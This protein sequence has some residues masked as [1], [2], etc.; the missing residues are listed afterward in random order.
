[1]DRSTAR[2]RRAR[3]ISMAVLGVGVAACL[4][5]GAVLAVPLA[6]ASEPSQTGWW[7]RA[8]PDAS[9]PIGG[10]PALPSP[11]VPEDGLPVALVLGEPSRVSGLGVPVDAAPGAT[12]TVATL[13]I[14]ELDGG[15]T[16]G[17]ADAEIVACP[18]LEFW[19]GEPAQAYESLPELDC[20]LAVTGERSE[21]GTWTFDLAIIATAWLDAAGGLSPDG[22]A[23][24]PAEDTEGSFQVVYDATSAVVD[25]QTT[26]GDDLDDPFAFDDGGFDDV[27]A[28][29]AGFADPGPI[30]GGGGF[31]PGPIGG[32]GGFDP[33]SIGSDLPD[34]GPIP[35]PDPEPTDGDEAAAPTQELTQQAAS[36]S[37]MGFGQLPGPVWLLFPLVLA[38]AAATSY[39]LG[40]AGEPVAAAEGRSVTRAL[41]ARSRVEDPR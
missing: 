13:T 7:D 31:D 1:V 40:P 32:G 27:P 36:A 5:L 30:D 21:D 37:P 28:P 24:L 34:P 10:A 29:D 3:A 38:L 23:L 39:A 25:L 41:L 8:R 12:V 17:A 22:V 16:A 14:D 35:D 19:V 2:A 33:P 6:S 4:A 9:T 26:G 15:G 20:D 11:D 18:I